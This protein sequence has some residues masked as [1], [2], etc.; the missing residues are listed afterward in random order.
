MKAAPCNA[1]SPKPA[2]TPKRMA[3][4]AP[5]LAPELIP[6]IYG[7][8]RAFRTTACKI[9]PATARPAPTAAPKIRRGIRMSQIT[10]FAE[11]AEAGA[12][13]PKILCAKAMRTSD[14]LIGVG[15]IIMPEAKTT[16]SR[17]TSRIDQSVVRRTCAL[18][19][20]MSESVLPT[21]LVLSGSASPCCAPLCEADR[22][23]E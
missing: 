13:A 2:P 14:R 12:S 7:S 8:A 11:D 1:Y 15:P 23:S 6:K 16:I 22:A 10:A 19:P 20:R 21:L 18:K 17:S 4:A 9:A 3:S 5:V